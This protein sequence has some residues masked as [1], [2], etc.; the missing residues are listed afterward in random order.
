M[1]GSDSTRALGFAVLRGRTV[2]PDVAATAAMRT[3]LEAGNADSPSSM[4]GERFSGCCA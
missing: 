4:S 3:M 1:Q 2:S